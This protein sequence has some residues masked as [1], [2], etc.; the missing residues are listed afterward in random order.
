MYT[1][2]HDKLMAYSY[3]GQIKL[4]QSI[5]FNNKTPLDIRAVVPTVSDLATML[6]PYVGLLTY[7]QEINRVFCCKEVKA[8]GTSIWSKLASD[9]GIP[10]YTTDMLSEL[11]EQPTKYIHLKSDA[12]LDDSI[13][14][15][16]FKTTINGNYA[17]ILFSALKQLQL[18]VARLKN[19]FVYGINSY[20]GTDT[21]LSYMQQ[22]YTTD[23][24]EEP[25]WA[26]DESDLTQ[27]FD[28]YAADQLQPA[29]G[30]TITDGTFTLVN[31]A[32]IGNLSEL[33]AEDAKLILYIDSSNMSYTVTL[34]DGT[35]INFSGFG[36]PFAERYHMMMCISRV[37]KEKG[38]NFIWITIDNQKTDWKLK[39]G[40]FQAPNK[41]MSGKTGYPETVTIT[42]IHFEPMTLYKVSIGTKYQDFTD[43]VEPMKP[44]EDD[45]KYKAAHIT[46][47]SVK[48]YS[49]LERISKH[50]Q[51][52]ELVYVEEE[53]TKN[54]KAGLYIKNHNTI[55]SLSGNT[56]TIIKPGDD[57]M[58][59]SELISM[60]KEIG[61]VYEENNGSL[62]LNNLK[63]ITFIHEDTGKVFNVAIDAYG[64]L[65]SEE[66]VH[67]TIESRLKALGTGA[68]EYKNE[69]GNYKEY[70]RGF[71]GKL[72]LAEYKKV[73][74]AIAPTSDIKL[75]ADRVKIGAFYAPRS[76]N[77]V[78]GCS[79]AYIELE[80]TGLYD[81]NLTGCYL[82]YV[83]KEGDSTKV[84]HLTLAGVIPAGGTYLIRGKK[85]A[86]Y[87][88]NNTFIKV[89]SFDQE[90]YM[91]N[92]QLLDLTYVK[93]EPYGFA[94][95]YGEP[96]LAWNTTLVRSNDNT[97]DTSDST[98]GTLLFKNCYIDA[99]YFSAPVAQSN[100]LGY[101]NNSKNCMDLG[102]NGRKDL[103]ADVIFKN[104]F[105]LDPAK[106]AFQALHPKDSSRVRH[107]N[108]A[109]YYYIPLENEYLS[110]P[111]STPR[112]P[113]ERFTPKASFE[114]KTVCTD[115]SR[116]DVNK[117][118]MVTCSFGINTVNTR[119]F[120]WVSAGLFDEY[121]W[122]RSA[123]GTTWTERFESYKAGTPD[124]QSSTN[125]TRKTFSTD[126]NNAVYAR[127]TSRFPA[128]NQ[129]FTAHKCILQC[130]T[131]DN[132]T[133][134]AKY[135]YVVGR[136]LV[137][138]QPDPEHMSDIMQFTLYPANWHPR[139]WHTSDQQGFHWVEYQVWAAS[140]RHILASMD[141][142]LKTE[143]IVPVLIN[144]GDMT[145][146]G[147]RINEWLD[148]YEAGKDLFKKY[149]QMNVV[150]NN[151]LCG[152]VPTELGTGDDAGK[153]NSYYFH[154]FYCYEV[155][156]NIPPIIKGKVVPSLYY[157]DFTDFRILMVNSELTTINAEQWFGL[158]HNGKTVNP[159]TGWVLDAPVYQETAAYKSA[160]YYDGFT[161]V[162]TMLYKM[163]NTTKRIIP[164]CHEMPFTVITQENI[165]TS[166]KGVSRSL[167]GTSLVGS[168]LNQLSAVDRVSP[169]WFSRLLEYK[170]VRLC[171]GGHKHTYAVTYP[172]RE[173]YKYTV[174]GT[175]YD[176]KANGC[177]AMGENLKNDN[178]TFVWDNTDHSKFPLMTKNMG[179]STDSTVMYPYTYTSAFNT[180]S[181][182][183]HTH[184]VVY[185]M[186]QSTGFKLFSN[187]ELPSVMQKFSQFIPKSAG[188]SKAS[189]DQRSPMYAI[190]DCTTSGYK[191]ELLKLL[192]I[193]RQPDK[194]FTPL[195]HG[196]NAIQP[197]YLR[198]GTSSESADAQLY[199]IWTNTKT[200]LMTIS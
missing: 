109:D 179:T 101:W 144:T 107:Q 69:S 57:T 130:K 52:N 72:G 200:T 165:A 66:V 171:L 127:I 126:I 158:T 134:V 90:W 89:K 103:D 120:N 145:Q 176:S 74:S 198:A 135:E 116:L 35:A 104:S 95:T 40:Y 106:Q 140:A 62:E 71:V 161:P 166:K 1:I 156:P 164:V 122:V 14:D 11:D 186:L 157:F 24:E 28:L 63:G 83:Y 27:V 133:T 100:G 7:V 58:D 172:L 42:N 53:D 31:A 20:T 88:D 50:I 154:L 189:T 51:N 124:A 38:E 43:S 8:D 68:P 142:T 22:Q 47:R 150:G 37:V 91:S 110:F 13:N 139:I 129:Q 26:I 64:N 114:G 6:N 23:I 168:H 94:L 92:K 136:S 87:D 32:D 183:N 113:V 48:D 169:Y 5:E 118:N 76:T 128:N 98:T 185:F 170:H 177:M 197:Q 16:T 80:N 115:K 194:L 174:N 67:N 36:L 54:H 29:T 108:I 162:Y 86:E 152:T 55:I 117:P 97:T 59:Q 9:T 3:G 96:E 178:V 82:H 84:E 181:A 65:K 159:Y 132:R 39:E 180:N 46:I 190:I 131:G 102:V 85:Y 121:I 79:H 184:G 60:L 105:M 34:S 138:G 175:T 12:D 112:Y 167:K 137:N 78:Y 99:L 4:D 199:G 182:V 2:N 41:L 153:S 77:K 75:Y 44:S 155:D 73:Q 15:N 18:E 111:K 61:V 93:G 163:M 33:G 30:I 17:D 160:N 19:S 173:Y 151:D 45:Y 21:T 141:N 56:S 123:G 188:A 70:T 187:K 148:Y 143:H 195:D 25:L 146:S 147:A 196:T 193:Q 119:C 81:F 149:E 191:I 49:V 10:I 192:N 125:W